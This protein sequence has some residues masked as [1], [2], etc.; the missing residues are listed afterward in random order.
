M[1]NIMLENP[2]VLAEYELDKS[3]GE[4]CRNNNKNNNGRSSES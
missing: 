2:T 4:L 1:V 3:T